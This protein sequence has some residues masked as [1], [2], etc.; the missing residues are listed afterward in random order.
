MQGLRAKLAYIYGAMSEEDHPAS[1]AGARTGRALFALAVFHC[2]ILERSRF[3]TLGFNTKYDFSETDFQACLSACM[4]DVTDVICSPQRMT[5]LPVIHVIGHQQLFK[6]YLFVGV[7]CSQV[8]LP[9]CLMGRSAPHRPGIHADI[10]LPPQVASELV[11]AHLDSADSPWEALRCLV[12][13]ATYGGRITDER[14]RRVVAAYLGRLFCE[15][16]MAPGATLAPAPGYSMP[17]AATLAAVRVCALTMSVP[18]CKL[19]KS[20]FEA[21]RIMPACMACLFYEAA[22]AH[23]AM[24]MPAPGHS[25]PCAASLVAVKVWNSTLPTLPCKTRHARLDICHS[26]YVE[27]CCVFL[28]GVGLWCSALSDDSLPHGQHPSGTFSACHTRHLIKQ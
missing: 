5:P 20:T 26:V 17:D 1:A 3:L 8:L 4:P 11:R 9:F 16:A 12:G 25:M 15:A 28:C 2:I 24:L 23:G 18:P 21:C 10:L 7:A 6:V 13:E 27:V 19:L 22:V 14:D